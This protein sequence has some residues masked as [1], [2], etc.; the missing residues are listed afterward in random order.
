MSRLV[1]DQFA[2]FSDTLPV[3][4]EIS[5][6]TA[7]SFE[8][9][10]MNGNVRVACILGNLFANG[11]DTP[12]VKFQLRCEFDIHP[13]DSNSLI[14]DKTLTLPT[15]LMGFFATQTIGASRGA[16]YFKTENTPFAGLI[17]PP[18]NVNEMFDSDLRFDLK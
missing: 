1:I 10:D 7:V 8:V 11:E 13:E 5:V 4:G 15:H 18:I 17:L 12:L 6:S 16:L 14:K 2:V 3:N 9:A